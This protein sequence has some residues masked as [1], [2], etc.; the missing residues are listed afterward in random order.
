M[1]WLFAHPDSPPTPSNSADFDP[2][3]NTPDDVKLGPNEMERDESRTELGRENLS[4]LQ[5]RGQ[6]GTE[7]CPSPDTERDGVRPNGTVSS[8][9]SCL[10]VLVTPVIW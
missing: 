10:L 1:P 6:G 2:L 7:K 9:S 3:V 8:T 5:L 4:Q